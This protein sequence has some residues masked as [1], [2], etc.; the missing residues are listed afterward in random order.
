M[1]KKRWILCTAALLAA[2]FCTAAALQS[3]Q[4]ELAKKLIRLHVVANSDSEEDQAVKLLVRDAVLAVTEPLL[5]E[6]AQP[7]EAL[8][9]ALPE[10]RRAARTCLREN[11]FS[12]GVE[13]SF[14]MERFPTRNYTG[15]SLPAGVYRSLRVRIGAGEG[16]NWWCVVFPSICFRATAAELEE[17]AAAGG[18]TEGELR[19]IT[20]A[21]NGYELKFKALELLEQLKMK[22]FSQSS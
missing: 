12:H 2:V 5:E 21:G 18:F 9:A 1:T 19:L 22:L 11:G 10:I 17:A 6:S 4:Q 7:E 15:F 16:H 20:E 13:V 8:Y 14:G 3:Q